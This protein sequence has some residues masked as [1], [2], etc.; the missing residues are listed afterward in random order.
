MMPVNPNEAQVHCSFCGASRS[1]AGIMIV[2]DGGVS[3]CAACVEVCAGLVMSQL[4][5]LSKPATANFPH[6]D[7]GTPV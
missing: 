5:P 4:K 6:D 2:A 7:M 1:G 3:I